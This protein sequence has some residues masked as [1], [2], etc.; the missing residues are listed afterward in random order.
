M[1]E[2]RRLFPPN[3]PAVRRRPQRQRW[4]PRIPLELEDGI[5]QTESYDALLKTQR[6]PHRSWWQALRQSPRRRPAHVPTV[7]EIEDV[8]QSIRYHRG[9]IELY[10]VKGATRAI[11]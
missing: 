5:I 7:I 6:E 10:P 8:R 1:D 9:L 3:F 2:L 11:T 4:Y